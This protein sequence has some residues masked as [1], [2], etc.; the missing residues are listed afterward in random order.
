LILWGERDAILPPSYAKSSPPINGSSRV[1][2]VAQAGHL[3]YL[4]QPDAVA[5]AVLAHFA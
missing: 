2:T 4:D 1:Q 5:Q 3:A